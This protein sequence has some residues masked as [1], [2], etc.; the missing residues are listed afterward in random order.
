MDNSFGSLLNY[1]M[2]DSGDYT[3]L[4]SDI[5]NKDFLNNVN[6]S[7][8]LS[9]F[10][11]WGQYEDLLRQAG[12]S[13]GFSRTTN[14]DSGTSYNDPGLQQWLTENNSPTNISGYYTGQGYDIG[15]QNL[16]GNNYLDRVFK[17]GQPTEH[18][19][20]SNYSDPRFWAAGQAAMALMS[21]GA[22]AA[23]LGSMGGTIGSSIGMGSGALGS[24]AGNALLNTGFT[25]V[26]GG[27][28]EDAL[29]NG[30]ISMG[31][32]YL[33]Q[34]VGGG[35]T[36]WFTEGGASMEPGFFDSYVPVDTGSFDFSGG[37]MGMGFSP[38]IDL[39]GMDLYN[40]GGQDMG[41]ETPSLYNSFM[42]MPAA[43]ESGM[44]G[45]LMKFLLGN[46]GVG[47]LNIGAKDILG[48]LSALYSYNRNSK[49]LSGQQD[50]LNQVTNNL[51]QQLN[52]QMVNP[53]DLYGPNSPYA[54]QLR[55]AL[56]RRDAAAGRRSQYGPREVE[57][58][59]K[60]APLATQVSS[61][62]QNTLLQQAGLY[63]NTIRPRMELSQAQAQLRGQ[64]LAQLYTMLIKSGVMN[65]L[66]S[67]GDIFSNNGYSDQWAMGPNAG[68]QLPPSNAIT[69]DMGLGDWTFG[70]GFGG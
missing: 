27:N 64:G 66:P 62:N 60:L 15:R 33:G 17:D 67:L 46:K 29:K 1:N 52:K 9:A 31:G 63:N 8:N 69:P 58:L 65:R 13:G 41:M 48:G 22:S 30:L 3:M 37:G 38:N 25:S 11:E 2:G 68:P 55:Q 50:Q 26:T 57:L 42:D 23:G 61:Q 53:Q 16:M 32:N 4:S 39:G 6:E 28:T 5:S 7:G 51:N 14:N 18:Y 54:Q 40:S 21:G 20:M 49:A 56:E 12:F 43:N 44:G 24:A 47:G 59:A 10:G 19:R 34:R 35:L 45:Q 70:E 36:N